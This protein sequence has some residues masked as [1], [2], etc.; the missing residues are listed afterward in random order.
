MTLNPDLTDDVTVHT[1]CKD[2]TL[3]VLLVDEIDEAT[4]ERHAENMA[5]MLDDVDAAEELK[6]DLTER[7]LRETLQADV[8][9]AF[10]PATPTVVNVDTDR[11]VEL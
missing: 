3:Y 9:E 2:G 8:P 6:D 7:A 5:A 4:L 1:K 11:D 10:D